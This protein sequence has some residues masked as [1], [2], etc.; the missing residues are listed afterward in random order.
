MRIFRKCARIKLINL[1]SHFLLRDR[2]EIEI[3]V[4]VY[5]TQ[6]RHA[7]KACAEMRLIMKLTPEQQE[8]L[9][10]K[11]LPLQIADRLRLIFL[12]LALFI[13]LFLFFGMKFW[14]EAEWFLVA[15]TKLYNFLFCDVIFMLLAIVAKVIFTARYNRYVKSL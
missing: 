15:Q 13:V 1:F 5:L 10:K 9:D 14:G 7:P 11:K 4:C 6:T 12:F 3:C 2:E 8:A